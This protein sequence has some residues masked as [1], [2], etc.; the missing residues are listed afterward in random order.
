MDIQEQKRE[1]RRKIRSLK[2]EQT[3]ADNESASSV[4]AHKLLQLEGIS[5][6]RTI[7]LYHSLPDEVSTHYM[8][9]YLHS[10]EG[11]SKRIILPVVEGE[12]LTLKEYNPIEMEYGYR[13]IMEP[14]G[15]KD[16]DPSEIEL[17]VIPGVA[18]DS[19][20]NRMGRGKGFYDKLLP[21]L[22]CPKIGLGYDFQIVEQIPCCNHDIPLNMVITESATYCRPL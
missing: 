20:C 3:T 16:V 6:S 4:I 14:Q 12:Y 11:G 5:S 17:A 21:Y 13:N 10:I 1:I 8:I 7:L 19:N 15:G 22:K 2:G 18:F 9:K